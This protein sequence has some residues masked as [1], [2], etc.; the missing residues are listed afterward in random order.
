MSDVHLEI[1]LALF[2]DMLET[3]LFQ[4]FYASDEAATYVINKIIY[5]R[6]GNMRQS[7][8]VLQLASDTKEHKKFSHIT[9]ERALRNNNFKMEPVTNLREI[10]ER[11]PS[12]FIVYCKLNTSF[13]SLKYTN[14]NENDNH[15]V[16]IRNGMILCPF[17]R[18]NGRPI[19]LSVRKHLSFSSDKAGLNNTRN[20]YINDAV[21]AFKIFSQI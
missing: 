5:P 7:L 17:L 2:G 14:T 6:K 9:L 1:D 13:T 12:V 4:D 18:D 19:K 20:S 11:V 8:Q 15:V 21:A 10:E 16:L 3:E